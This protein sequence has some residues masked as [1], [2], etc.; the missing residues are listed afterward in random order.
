[1][2]GLPE[3]ES[4]SPESLEVNLV[5]L[6]QKSDPSLTR[7]DIGIA[8]RNGRSKKPDQPGRS[9]TCVLTRASKKDRLMRKDS[10]SKLKTTSK[11]MLYHR[12]SDGLR[13]RKKDL[14]DLD[15]VNWVAFSGHRLFTV[16]VK[17]KDGKDNF[18]KNVLRTEQIEQN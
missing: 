3:A 18:I 2:A 8:H 11:V 6:L 15:G 9:I 17:D 14:E 13:K 5:E 7:H 10:R 16:C 1:M 12:M 4:E